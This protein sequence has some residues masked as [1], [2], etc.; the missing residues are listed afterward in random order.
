MTLN[1]AD[2][3][4]SAIQTRRADYTFIAGDAILPQ[5]AFAALVG[6]LTARAAV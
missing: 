6:R 4:V 1:I 5:V 2:E 3:R